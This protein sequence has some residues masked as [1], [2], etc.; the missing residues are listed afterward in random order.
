MIFVDT[1]VVVDVL[2]RY[3]PA[4][5]WLAKARQ[6]EEVVL[7]GYVLMELIQGCRHR[8]EQ[9]RMRGN[10]ESYRVIWPTEEEC[11]KA[12]E[13]LSNYHLSAGI[14]ILDALI[15]EMALARDVPLHMFNSKHYQSIPGLKMTQPY[16][17]TPA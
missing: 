8:E 6:E 9:E 12:V 1:D 14:G 3:P 4:M 15:A 16:A 11:E 17:R 7:R 13:L 2:R 10:V 5:E